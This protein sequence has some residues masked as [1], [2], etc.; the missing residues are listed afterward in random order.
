MVEK[1]KKYSFLIYHRTY[2]EFLES[3][4]QAGV[5]HITEKQQGIPEDAV[6]LRNRL[7]TAGILQSTIRILQHKLSGRE[8]VCLQPVNPDVDPLQIPDVYEQ[9]KAQ[10]DALTS[11]QQALRKEIDR[12]SVWGDFDWDMLYRLKDAGWEL[13]FYSCREREFNAGWKDRFNA[14][15]IAMTGVAAY[16][17]TIMPAGETE[18]PEAERIRL[19]EQP[20]NRLQAMWQDTGVQLQDVERQ[21]LQM[22][23]EHL[24]TLKEALRRVNEDIDLSKV[25][26]H[27]EKK[28]GD[29]LILLEGW[30]PQAKEPEL[31]RALEGQ[32]V[33][34]TG[35]EPDKDDASAPVLLKN[36]RFAR[37]FE[38]ITALYDLPNYHELDLTPFFA[39]F[40]LMFFGLCLGDAGYGLLLLAAAVIL[41]RKMKP[42]MRPMFTLVAWL[43]AG[44][45]VFGTVSGTFFGI[46]LL[47][48]SWEWLTSFKKIMLD[49][50]KL[51]NLALIIGAVQIIFG[52]FVKAI[53]QIRRYGWAYSLETWGWLLLIF[54]GAVFL[55]GGGQILPP[56]VTRYAC[57]AVFGV[58]GIFIFLLNKPGRN[59]LINIGAGLWNSYNMV[60]GL[61]GDLLSYIRLFA[62]GISGS[63]MGLVF[64]QLAVNMSGDI[65]VVS[66]LVMLIILLIG[67]SLNI[68]M[69]GLGA[70]VHPMRLTFVE[71][72]KNAGFEGN[73]KKYKPFKRITEEG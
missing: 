53:G 26:L 52:M 3:I 40:F 12:M 44:T 64:N 45:M 37:L 28:A 14:V 71:F 41:R 68:F 36:N 55:T 22:A 32:D 29:S 51:F 59:P 6:D 43:G 27:A 67:H 63:V 69:S 66:W 56:E 34:Y 48:V 49:S 16:F 23:A 1:M 39:P 42:A 33:W 11:R 47:E 50:N 57:Y 10:Q 60:T 21:M 4:R 35:K 61:M 20:L 15:E 17:V 19:P 8:E 73:G 24:N 9:L 58:A 31:L 62:L 2:N 65:P 13:K 70:F 7:K 46:P 25:R 38:P 18:E 5:V 30:A 54:G 72:Y